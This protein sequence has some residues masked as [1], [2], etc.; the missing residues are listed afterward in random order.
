MH[1]LVPRHFTPPVFVVYGMQ[2]CCKQSKSGS[3]YR[4]PGN[5]AKYVHSMLGILG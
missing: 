1:S 5:E 2:E 3:V 4:K